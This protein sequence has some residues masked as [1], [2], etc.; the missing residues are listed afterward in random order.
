MRVKNKATNR[1]PEIKARGQLLLQAGRARRGARA[2]GVKG[3]GFWRNRAAHVASHKR[4]ITVV[5]DAAKVLRRWR[6]NL[7]NKN[8]VP[9][10]TTIHNDTHARVVVQQAVAPLAVAPNAPQLLDELFRGSLVH[11]RR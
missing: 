2:S 7:R 10:T 9:T 3:R 5:G 6:T 4:V 8:R 11:M 1:L